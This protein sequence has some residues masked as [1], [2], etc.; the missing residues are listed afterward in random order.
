[1][2]SLV[3]RGAL[4]ISARISISHAPYRA[5]RLP[6]EIPRYLAQIL[7]PFLHA[8][9]DA[10][11]DLL[12]IALAQSR[13]EHEVRPRRHFERASN[14]GSGHQGR[15]GDLQ[16]GHVGANGGAISAS[17]RRSAGSASRPVTNR[18]RPG[19]GGATSSIS[20]DRR[21]AR[22]CSACL[23]ARPLGR[24]PE[25]GVLDP[26][27]EPEILVR[28]SAGAVRHQLHRHPRPRDREV[29]VSGMPLQRDSR[30][31]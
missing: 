27:G 3:S 23:R 12:W 31:R 20:A 10:T 18:T 5:P 8:H 17:T 9:A 19:S 6:Y 13:N 16:D 14:P 22:T 28:N 11:G 15:H 24:P 29:R 2:A 21:C 26:A 25:D 7:R 30:S 4:L 1:M